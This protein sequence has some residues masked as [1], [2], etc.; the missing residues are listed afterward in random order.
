MP[1]LTYSPVAQGW[2]SFYS[3]EPEFMIG[4][5]NHFYSWD[6]GRLYRHDTGLGRNN[7]YGSPF[8][9][10]ITTVFNDAP[11]SNLLWKTIHLEG[12]LPWGATMATDIQGGYIDSSWFEKKEAAWFAFVRNN[13]LVDPS[14]FALR[15]AIG[16]GITTEVVQDGFEF[17]L[18]FPFDIGT[19]L[20]Q[21]DAIYGIN[22]G[23]FIGLLGYAVSVTYDPAVN[24]S[25][26]VYTIAGM[27]PTPPPAEAGFHIIYAKDGVGESSGVRGHY[28][29][30]TLTI[31]Q[32]IP[33]EL[34]AVESEV[35]AS[36]PYP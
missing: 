19:M 13:D 16:V 11:L 32:S 15:S 1:T 21:G 35:M 4:M 24:E 29:V 23:Q 5:N 7:F 6:R 33:V 31:D 18:T 2:P 26:L 36:F 14:G 9:S 25:Y 28:N 10:T 30:I 27:Q 12:N 22:N 3:Y 20:H 34:F 17:T 8:P